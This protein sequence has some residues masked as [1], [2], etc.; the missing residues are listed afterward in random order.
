MRREARR[1]LRRL[2]R[3]QL[4][5]ALAGVGCGLGLALVGAAYA[6]LTGP[7]LQTV[8]S[9]GIQGPQHFLRWIPPSLRPGAMGWRATGP[10]ALGAVVGL[11]IGLALLKGLLHLAQV[12]LL[13]RSSEALGHALRVRVYQQ[14]MH[15]PLRAQRER[16]SGELLTRLLDDTRQLRGL[17]FDLPLAIVRESAAVLAL[18]LA[19][20]W[21]APRLAALALLALPPVVIA[22]AAIARR[23]RHAAARGQSALGELGGRAAQAL[24]A[25]R[26]IKSCGAEAREVERFSALSEQLARSAVSAVLA[27]AV[28][29][30]VNELSAATALGLTLAFGAWQVRVGAVAPEALVSFVAAVLLAYRPL[31]ALTQA[32][33]AR[34]A[35]QPSRARVEELLGWPA[36]LPSS[37]SAAVDGLAPRLAGGLLPPLCEGL[38]LR[39][40]AFRYAQPWVLDGVSLRLR[41]GEIVAV[42][43]RSGAGKSALADLLAGLEPWERGELS[44]DGWAWPVAEGESPVALARALR[45]QVALVPQQPL[46]LD[47]TLAENLRFA[48]PSASEAALWE[49]LRWAGLAARARALPGGLAARLGSGGEGLS[50]GEV[51]RLAV[52]RALLRRAPLLVL[53]EPTAALDDETEQGLLRTLGS[54][55][56]GRAMLLVTHRPAAVALADRVLC[57]EGGRLR[58]VVPAAAPAGGPAGSCAGA[59]PWQGVAIV[60]ERA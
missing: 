24:R 37:E 46:L 53:D 60:G 36:E 57:L 47:G 15:L 35:A 34:A 16:A 8:L 43:G 40:L 33:H 31:K 18:G 20:A 39:A 7:L 14:L 48:A 9:G 12:A 28:G 29:P 59:P 30:L 23:V 25:Q 10:G 41:R 58:S 27:R 55:R 54:L 6:Y 4:P 32:L 3:P 21:T 13:E 52:A 50:V 19:A 5:R 42:V 1:E 26:E 2:Q 38:E 17:L 11:L 44:W 51:Q 22:V 49:A 56:A 45:R